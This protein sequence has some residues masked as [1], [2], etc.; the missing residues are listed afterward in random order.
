[1]LTVIAGLAEKFGETACPTY[2]RC[3]NGARSLVQSSDSPPRAGYIGLMA[4]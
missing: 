1:M 4:R 3:R 2:A